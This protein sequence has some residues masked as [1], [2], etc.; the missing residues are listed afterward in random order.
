MCLPSEPDAMETRWTYRPE[1]KETSGNEHNYWFP[2]NCKWKVHSRSEG[3]KQ[4]DGTTVRSEKKTRYLIIN[5][6]ETGSEF[7]GNA[8]V[9]LPKKLLRKSV[10]AQPSSSAVGGRRGGAK[11]IGQ[12]MFRQSYSYANV[13]PH[14]NS[15]HPAKLASGNGLPPMQRWRGMRI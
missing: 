14:D 12:H 5:V 11:E 1:I 2:T 4:R 7:S 13:P 9:Y 8:L 3:E 15:Y 10:A 6:V